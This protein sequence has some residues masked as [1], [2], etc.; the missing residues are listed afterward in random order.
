MFA[1]FFLVA[2]SVARI[3]DSAPHNAFT[4][5]V[6]YKDRWLCTFRE[7]SKHVSED[8]AIRI[9]ESRDGSTWTSAARLER[10]G[11]DIRDPKL[12]LTP[13]GRLMLTTA[14]ANRQAKPVTHQSIVWFS[15]DG[16]QWGEP[17]N[18]GELNFWLWRV[19]WHK[20]L[21]YSVGYSTGDRESGFARLYR[22][23]DGRN[24]ETL[25]PT[26]FRE[27][28]PNE[29]SIVFLK[30][31]T[32]LCLLRRDLGSRTGQLGTARPPYTDWSWIDLGVR[33]GGPHFIQIPGGRLIGVVRLY[34]GVQRTS[35][36][37]IDPAAGKIVELEKLPSS[38]DSS[39]AGLVWR[40][41][42]LWISYYSSHEGK[43]SIYLARWKP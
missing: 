37:E 31:G 9:L 36:V 32:A 41:G 23:R 27:G 18:V 34:D 7:G 12:T 30:D 33:I 13:D 5:L 3:W 20:D 21:A 6:H 4:D 25:V 15:K 19:Q 2:A 26:L 39:Y 14:A 40:D 24:F 1:A 42:Q 22:S 29:S 38:G 28:Y 16:R 10:A 17:V 35:I 8:G 43:S 11:L